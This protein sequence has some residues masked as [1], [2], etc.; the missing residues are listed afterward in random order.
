[1]NRNTYI[2]NMEV[3]EAKRRYLSHLKLTARV[4]E[5]PVSESLGRITAEAV[6]ARL[7]SPSYN[8]SAM[9]GIA[10]VAQRTEEA[11]ERNPITLT[12]GTDFDYVNTGNP[13]RE[14]YNAVIMIEDVL[15]QNEQ[16]VQILQGAYPWQHVRQIGEDIVK[17]EMILPSRHRIRPVDLG[18]LIAGGITQMRVYAQPRVGILPTG[19]EI[20]QEAHEVAVGK[21]IDSNS[22]VFEGLVQEYGGLPQRYV[23]HKDDKALLKQAIQTAIRD[24]DLLV[25]GAGSSAGTRDYTAELI[26]ELGTVVVHGVGIKPG[27]PTI[28]GSIDGKPV[29]GIPGYPVSAYIAFEEFVRPILRRLIGQD[30]EQEQRSAWAQLSR[31]VV[32]SLKHKELLRVQLGLVGQ[33][34]IATPLAGGAG[35]S[36]SL[37]RADAIAVIPRNQEGAEAGE[38]VEV[39][40]MKPMRDIERTIVSIGSHDLVMDLIADEMPLSSSHVGS[41]GGILALKRGECHLVPT[42]LLNEEDGSYNAS[43]VK[44]YF[45]NE[46]MVLIKGLQ[47]KQGF[48]VPKGNPRA[49][50]GF[51]DLLQEDLIYVN[52]QRGAGTRI[53][54]DYHLKQEGIDP[55]QIRGYQ[56]ELTTHMAVASAVESGAADVGLGVYSAAQAAG[57]D[58]VPVTDEEYD[59]LIRREMLDD[60]RIQQF[61]SILRS[62]AFQSRVT[63]LG[64]YGFDRAGELIEIG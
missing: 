4:E 21:I 41:L 62:E 34:L 33:R 44:Q 12:L 25:I 10:V 24:N 7:S 58:F 50:R 18:A 57:L 6:F 23:P 55:E 54:L 48:L 28:L 38:L 35:T 19:S 29:I 31:R 47:R 42:H 26:A 40:L 5:I 27:K 61:L 49:I 37:V 53:L 60:P 13:I 14:P 64:G 30:A 1:M 45:P 46:K 2:D 15:V 17:T 39:H 20:V 56:R 3:E 11:S 32:S 43:Y 22:W 16:Q 8:A 9:D 59:F 51:A 36:M 52:R 63:A